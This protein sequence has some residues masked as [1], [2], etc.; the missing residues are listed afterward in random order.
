MG[1]GP[2]F[3]PVSLLVSVFCFSFC[4]SSIFPSS[5]WQKER[6]RWRYLMSAYE[7][8][9]ALQTP[10]ESQVKMKMA[11]LQQPREIMV[12]SAAAKS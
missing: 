2:G 9:R 8:F 4:S 10:S 11:A 1:P 7:F 5:F 12:D 6:S 3:E